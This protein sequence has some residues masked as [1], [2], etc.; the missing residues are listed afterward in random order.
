MAGYNL[1]AGILVSAY[2]FPA[3]LQ[4]NWAAYAKLV[5]LDPAHGGPVLPL[6][7]TTSPPAAVCLVN[8]FGYRVDVEFYQSFCREH[9]VL[10]W[11]DNAACPLHLMPDG[12]NITSLADAAVVSLHETKPIGRGEGG[13]LIVPKELNGIAHRAICFGFESSAPPEERKH[14]PRASNWKMSDFQAAAV[15]MHWELAWE[16]M[17]SW[18]I[19]HDEDIK[20]VGPF[21]RGLPGTLVGCLMEPRRLRPNVQVRHYYK[22][23]ATREQAPVAWQVFDQLQCTPFHIPDP[24]K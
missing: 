4:G 16:Q 24:V 21:K 5:D 23:L 10:L 2:S 19:A 12:S 18:L 11:M 20:D 17:R 1:S 22:P 13:L 9:E 14:D 6:P 7:G 8:P 15:L 3:V